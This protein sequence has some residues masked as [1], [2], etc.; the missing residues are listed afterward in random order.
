LNAA[1]K[2]DPSRGGVAWLM[3]IAANVLREQQRLRLRRDVPA[4]DLGDEAW[5]SLLEGLHSARS[6]SAG[7]LDVQQTLS[8]LD[9]ATRR[10]LE[11][12]FFQGL[13]GTELARAIEAP[14]AGAARVRLCRALRSLRERFG[15]IEGEVTT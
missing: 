8:E 6:D 2:F 12:H 15:G 13:D 3:A 10:M 9:A 14:S 5:R 11:L 7:R 1:D 4:S